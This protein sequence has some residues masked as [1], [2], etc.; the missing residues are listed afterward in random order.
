MLVKV[1]CMEEP[2]NTLSEGFRVLVHLGAHFLVGATVIMAMCF[3]ERFIDFLWGNAEPVFFGTIPI[4]YVS[5]GMDLAVLIVFV[6]YGIV[7]LYRTVATSNSNVSDK[8]GRSTAITRL[9]NIVSENYLAEL[10]PHSYFAG[11]Y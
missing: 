5:R 8:A 2:K 9:S 3:L 6:L 4:R 10:E 7:S 11:C 1:A